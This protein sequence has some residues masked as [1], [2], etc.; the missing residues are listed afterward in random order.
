VFLL[1][2]LLTIGCT[3]HIY[4]TI[5]WVVVVIVVSLIHIMIANVVIVIVVD[6]IWI[7]ADNVYD[8]YGALE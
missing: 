3:L 7:F 8:E 4:A 1:L 5:I 6:D 2:L